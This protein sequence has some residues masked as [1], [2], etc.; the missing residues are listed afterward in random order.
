MVP[1]EPKR[2]PEIVISKEIWLKLFLTDFYNLRKKN[3]NHTQETTLPL[4]QGKFASSSII[5]SLTTLKK[6]KIV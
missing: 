1:S 6:I 4:K 2:N 5:S 3:G